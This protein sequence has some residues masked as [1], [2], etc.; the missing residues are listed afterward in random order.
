MQRAMPSTV[1]AWALGYA[2][3]LCDDMSILAQARDLNNASPLGSAAG[4]GVPYLN[5]DREALAED[6]GFERVQENV[7]SVQLSRGK[8]E[9]AAVHALVQAAATINRL[10]SD[11]ILYSTSEFDFGPFG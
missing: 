3:M 8:F 4:Y 7:T 6:L 11:I 2:E 9:L 1:A 5:L 10:A